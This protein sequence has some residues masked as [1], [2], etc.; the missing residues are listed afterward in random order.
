[1]VILIIIQPIGELATVNYN[2]EDRR[3]VGKSR[4]DKVVN[5]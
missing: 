2:V 3:R 1:M 4:E 5:K